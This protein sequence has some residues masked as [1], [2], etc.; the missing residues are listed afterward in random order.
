VASRSPR[1]N[2]RQFLT[3]ALLGTGLAGGGR[4]ASAAAAPAGGIFDVK[5]FGAVGDG[6]TS[7]TRAIQRTLD[8]CA[9]EGGGLVLI[10]P[11]QYVSGAL[12]LRSNLELRLSAGAVLLGSERFQDYP[13]IKGRSEGVE[14]T[15]HSSLLTGQD[16]DNV[17]ISGSGL[18]DGRGPPWW[19]AHALTHAAR[20]EHKLPREAENPPGTPLKWPR[21]R[22][23]NLIRCRGVQVEGITVR[24]GPAWNIHLVYC[25][26][27][28]VHGVTALGLETAN[29]DGVVVDSCKH[30]RIS[31]CSLASGTDCIAIKS[32]YNEDGRRVGIC[33]EDVLVVNC[34]VSF[35]DGAGIAIGSET[36]GGIRNVTVSNCSIANSRY[37]IQIK[38]ARGRG[39][40]LECIRVSDVV[41]DQIH[42][43]GVM[44]S[45][46]YDSVE[47][48]VMFEDKPSG[49]PETDRTLRPPVGEGTPTFRDIS[50]RGLTMGQ[51]RR[52]AVIEGLP[53]R[54]IR[55]VRL[56]DV[57]ATRSRLG[58][59]CTRAADVVIRDVTLGPLDSPAVAARTVERLEVRGLSG[60]APSRGLPLVHLEEV[61]GAFVH[62]CDVGASGRELVGGS[63]DRNHDVVVT[64]NHLGP[65]TKTRT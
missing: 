52:V 20:V 38:S 10:P 29:L 55:G 31:D 3:G 25:E 8:A 40:V 4:G 57:T 36:A 46:Y 27:V 23:I 28:V 19:K 56:E 50:V 48:K 49:N 64:G 59:V 21:P 34:N 41:L 39:G 14:R 9:A 45:K 15:I 51:V 42:D 54:F 60:A 22:L 18:I 7:C 11:G 63:G 32:G 58:V 26:D 53:E 12:F 6:K 65:D 24:D 47:W 16:L 13:P 43:S 61:A 2:R 30:V 1:G 35:S 33:C 5:R 17:S 44:I 37:G 62:G